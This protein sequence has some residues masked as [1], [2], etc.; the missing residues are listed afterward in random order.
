[1]IHFH[2][3]NSIARLKLSF[4]TSFSIVIV[5]LLHK[6][7]KNLCVCVCV[8][9]CVWCVCTSCNVLLLWCEISTRWCFLSFLSHLYTYKT[10]NMKT[11]SKFNSF[12]IVRRWRRRISSSLP[13]FYNHEE[14]DTQTQTQTQSLRIQY[15]SYEHA[16]ILS[17]HCSPK[18]LVW[19]VF[20]IHTQQRLDIKIP[21]GLKKK[22]SLTLWTSIE[23]IIEINGKE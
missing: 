19:V 22:K 15:H 5:A 9:F 11:D 2:F 1:M 4:H 8:C 3:R 13:K 23:S 6:P 14:K 18:S 21:G 20:N 12:A 10:G 7:Q 16:E 17:S